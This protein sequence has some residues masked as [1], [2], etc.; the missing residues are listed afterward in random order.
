[1]STVS[2]HLPAASMDEPSENA[3]F[4]LET[5]ST[6][7]PPQTTTRRL[8]GKS[9]CM[10][11]QPEMP[12]VY[13]STLLDKQHFP[14][15]AAQASLMKL[16]ASKAQWL[17]TSHQGLPSS[18]NIGSLE[19]SETKSD[20]PLAGSLTNAQIISQ[21]SRPKP[22]RASE[23]I[24]FQSVS[25]LVTGAVGASPAQSSAMLLR[26]SGYSRREKQ[27]PPAK[28]SR[29]RP[30]GS[31]HAP[32]AVL[33]KLLPNIKPFLPTGPETFDQDR[34]LR[35]L[36]TK[37]AYQNIL[38]GNQI[39]G[40]SYPSELS[41]NLEAKR[42]S[43]KIAEQGR[44]NRL[45][46]ALQI[47][48]SLLPDINTSTSMSED[49][50]KFNHFLN[51]KASIVENAIVHIRS[52]NKENADLGQEVQ[53]LK[54]QLQSLKRSIRRQQYIST[55]RYQRSKRSTLQAVAQKL[56]ET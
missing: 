12:L 46:S 31:L 22:S 15:L 37:S 13:S 29:K 49:D 53:V 45:K 39:P 11:P 2:F 36:Q 40:V 47:M 26:P 21:I 14:H 42:I 10:R 54:E 44:R 3:S 35:L 41:L 5:I 51:S 4:S 7:P 23:K 20:T 6:V 52:L 24:K 56:Q 19:L 8:M 30:T 9:S 43:R 17:T 33:P 32:P 28:N 48:A 18:G 50:N 16:P 25:S 55:K 34:T 27:K 1:M 38:E